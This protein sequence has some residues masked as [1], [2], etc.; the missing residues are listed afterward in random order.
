MELLK[1]VL[2]ALLPVV[3]YSLFRS[4]RFPRGTIVLIIFF[5][6]LFPDLV[7]KPLAWTLGITPSGRMITHSLVIALPLI[8]GVLIAAYRASWFPH[9]VAFGWGYLSHLCGDFYPVFLVGSEYYYYPNMFW[10]LLGANPD[11]DP[12]FEG[13]L[14]IFGVEMLPELLLLLLV[15]GYATLDIMRRVKARQQLT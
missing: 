7:D 4:R 15:L 9:G 12:G 3:G 1:H 13:K 8:V 11:R 14:P 10:P 2:L 5:A 6:S